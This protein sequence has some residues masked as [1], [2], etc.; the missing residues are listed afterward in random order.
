MHLLEGKTENCTGKM[1]IIWSPTL[2]QPNK[3][4]DLKKQNDNKKQGDLRPNRVLKLEMTL[5]IQGF[6][7]L[8]DS[9]CLG[10]SVG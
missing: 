10:G 9:E 8:N 1:M 6:Q 7:M 5:E 3:E 4:W 2:E